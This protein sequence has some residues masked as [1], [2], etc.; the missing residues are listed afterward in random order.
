[1]ISTFDL[2]PFLNLGRAGARKTVAEPEDYRQRV[3]YGAH[4]WRADVLQEARTPR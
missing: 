4:S 3:R 1:M 2:T